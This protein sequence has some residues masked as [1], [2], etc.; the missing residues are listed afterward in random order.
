MA[1]I[2]FTGITTAAAGATATATTKAVYIGAHASKNQCANVFIPISTRT[3]GSVSVTNPCTL[4][5]KCNVKVLNGTKPYVG[6]IRFP[7]T[8]KQVINTEPGWVDNST[9]TLVDGVFTI[10]F[11]IG[12]AGSPEY[13]VPLSDETYK[14]EARGSGDTAFSS[15]TRGTGGSWGVLTIGNMEHNAAWYTDANFRA[16]FI[17]SNPTLRIVA[18]ASGNSVNGSNMIPDF[19]T[20]N[21]QGTYGL[22]GANASGNLTEARNHYMQAPAQTWSRDAM[23]PELVQFVTVDD[24]Y[25][26]ASRSYTQHAATSNTREYYT[27]SDFGDVKFEKLGTGCYNVIS[28]DVNKKAVVIGYDGTNKVANIYLPLYTHRYFQ[29]FSWTNSKTDFTDGFGTSGTGGTW[30]G[31]NV[32]FHI[33]FNA[34]R[35]S[36]TGQP[37]VGRLWADSRASSDNGQKRVSQMQAGH[38]AA[39]NGS[40]DATA[41]NSY[42]S[43]SY[44]ATTGAYS[45][46]VRF[47]KGYFYQL[48]QN[49]YN[50]FLTIGNAEHKNNNTY[51]GTFDSNCFGS[52]F[53]ISDIHISVYDSD[54]TTLLASEAAPEMVVGNYS[55]DPP[56]D[57]IDDHSTQR[58][59]QDCSTN[60]HNG[61]ATALYNIPA[62]TWGCDGAQQLVWVVNRSDCMAA[63]HTLTHYAATDTTREYWHCATCSKNYADAYASEVIT[64]TTA[65]KKMIVIKGSGDVHQN[66]LLPLNI[67][68]GSGT[69]YY[70]FTCD[71]EIFGN[72]IPTISMLRGSWWGGNGAMATNWTNNSSTPSSNLYASYNEATHKFEA[73][74]RIDHENSTLPVNYANAISGAYAG[75]LLGNGRDVGA[76]GYAD[77]KYYTSFAFA[78][79]HLYKLTDAADPN[80]TTGSDLCAPISDKTVN[81]YTGTWYNAT[82]GTRYGTENTMY[83]ATNPLSAPLGKWSVSGIGT[84]FVS[85]QNIPSGFFSGSATKHMLRTTGSVAT[86]TFATQ[87]LFLQKGQTY[88]FDIDYRDFGSTP[89]ITLESSTGSYTAVSETATASNVADMH[90]SVRFTMPAGAKTTGTGNFRLTLGQTSSGASDKASVY[91]ANPTLKLVSGGNVTGRNLLLGNGFECG[92]G[93]LTSGNLSNAMFG[94]A[95]NSSVILGKTTK[96]LETIPSGFFTGNR[97][98]LKGAAV[99]IDDGAM[100]LGYSLILPAAVRNDANAYVKFTDSTGS[101]NVL[102]ANAVEKNNTNGLYKF[103][104]PLMVKQ[105]NENVN[106]KV[107]NGSNQVVAMYSTGGNDYNTAGLNYSVQEYANKK[108]ESGNTSAMQELA[109][110]INDFGAATRLY[111][112]YG[113]TAGLSVSSASTAITASSV[114]SYQSTR[115]GTMPNGITGASI[116]LNLIDKTTLRIKF[117]SSKTS[118]YTFKIDGNTVNVGWHGDGYWLDVEGIAAKDLGTP[119]TFTVSDGVNTYTVTAS[120][121]TYARASIKNGDEARQNLGK[122]MA[123]YY[124]AADAYFG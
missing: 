79:P 114:S 30:S 36:G 56:T 32:F 95:P 113:N 55:F 108:Q 89:V 104:Y 24:S 51:D 107:Y 99:N 14:G 116:Q 12:N 60:N 7:R 87:E 47:N 91:F 62:D 13:G 59:F 63:N 2:P 44:N 88:Q 27:C 22:V 31:S 94:W 115:S 15:V 5:F 123:R 70:K 16:S 81:F 26:T 43:S 82:A 112:N 66:V 45:A 67:V 40:A 122:A 105:F 64:D 90:K 42:C 3:S 52:S 39:Y 77:T 75:L 109:G 69:H 119:H 97:V 76:N 33:T 17:M 1:V 50:E 85:A 100:A 21:D 11:T 73:V 121:M 10:R 80:S 106:I 78:N 58:Y 83:Y 54:N 72:E 103:A 53:V 19:G 65:T 48:T 41:Q 35:L 61:R 46:T 101:T 98:T 37:I 34:K 28:N 6:F 93:A 110:A 38:N 20:F 124:I 4:E 68:E 96:A 74:V 18:D 102:L 25:L 23:N 8:G 71:M 117:K 29:A 49:G 111:L 118:G 92:S 57:A 86:E 9:S 84:S 120:A